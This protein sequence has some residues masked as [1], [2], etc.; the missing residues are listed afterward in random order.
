MEQHAMIAA[1]LG[2]QPSEQTNVHIISQTPKD[3]QL[4][5]T[6]EQACN[7]VL[8][9][10][11]KLLFYNSI[12]TALDLLAVPLRSFKDTQSRRR[13]ATTPE[14]YAYYSIYRHTH[15]PTTETSI[16]F[17]S[18]TYFPSRQGHVPKN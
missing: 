6:H 8:Q 11:R 15:P 14:Q 17:P 3:F 9:I 16:P 7:H 18:H 13:S 2:T 10:T 12:R 5:G 4:E 1:D